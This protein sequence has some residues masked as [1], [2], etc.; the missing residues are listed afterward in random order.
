[1]LLASLWQGDQHIMVRTWVKS[2]FVSWSL[3]RKCLLFLGLAL[4]VSL[5]LGFFAVQLLAERLVMET[6]RQSAR[7]YAIAIV[8][9]NHVE[10][11]KSGKPKV[12]TEDSDA[13]QE[14]QQAES[15]QGDGTDVMK[16][17]RNSFLNPRFNYEILRINDGLEHHLLND[18]VANAEELPRLVKLNLRLAE[19]DSLAKGG[20]N[21]PPRDPSNPPEVLPSADTSPAVSPDPGNALPT[22]VGKPLPSLTNPGDRIFEEAGPIDNFYYYYHPIQFEA[23]CLRCHMRLKSSSDTPMSASIDPFR[24]VRVR[25]PY[26]DT[27]MYRVWSYSILTSI[28]IATLA[29][30]LLFIHWVLKRLVISPLSELKLVSEE[31]TKG[32]TNLQFRVDTDDDFSELSDSFNRMLRHLTETQFEL[33]TVN[34]KLD[35]RIDELASVNLQLFEANRL[36]GEFLANMSHELRTPLNSI[37][38]FSEV[39]AGIETL[40]DKQRRWVSNIQNSGRILLEMINDILDLAKVEAGKMEVRPADFSLLTVIGAQVEIFRKMAEDKNI[41]IQVDSNQAEMRVFQDQ[42]KLAQ[43]LTNLLSNAI[44]FTPEGG[45]VTIACDWIDD[46]EFFF[47]VSDTGVGIA[48]QEHEIIFEKFRQASTGIGKDSLTRE[49]TGTGLGLSIVRELCRLLGGDITLSSQLGQGSTFRVVLPRR[50]E[51]VPSLELER[52]Q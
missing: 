3:E 20:A 43:I 29:L 6:T 31:I 51:A 11:E 45:L 52:V 5:I 21:K 28:G 22:N 46:R 9:L 15:T 36:K 24:V 47:S 17:V 49:H 2:L 39:L 38:G 30:S 42:S 13:A 25:M 35:S 37:L 41:D 12:L 34:D 4:M 7:D 33:Q 19:M 14:R 50:Y 16:W 26:S 48:P 27:R 18:P 44:K 1:L 23:T 32:K 10:L 40:T 8:G